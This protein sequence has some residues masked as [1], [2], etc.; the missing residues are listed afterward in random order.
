[1]ENYYLLTFPLLVQDAASFWSQQPLAARE[2]ASSTIIPACNVVMDL[3]NDAHDLIDKE[4]SAFYRTP[5]NS[6]YMFPSTPQ[7]CC[8]HDMSAILCQIVLRKSIEL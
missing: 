1:M 7:V 8:Q 4:V 5:D 3:S 2:Y 6:L